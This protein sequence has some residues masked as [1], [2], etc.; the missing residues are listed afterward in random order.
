MKK[1]L[2]IIE[3]LYCFVNQHCNASDLF[4]IHINLR[5]GQRFRLNI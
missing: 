1:T 3:S 4:M 2:V 5:N